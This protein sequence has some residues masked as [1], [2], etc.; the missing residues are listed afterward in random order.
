MSSKGKGKGKRLNEFQQPEIIRPPNKH[1]L[2]RGHNISE[3]VIYDTWENRGV[4]WR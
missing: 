2:T 1:E 3:G 4:I